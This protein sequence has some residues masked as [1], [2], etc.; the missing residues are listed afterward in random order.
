M[1]L[2]LLFWCRLTGS[3]PETHTKRQATQ[4]DY[5]PSLLGDG[6]LSYWNSVLWGKTYVVLGRLSQPRQNKIQHNTPDEPSKEGLLLFVLFEPLFTSVST[7]S[8]GHHPSLV[9]LVQLP[10]LYIKIT[11]LTSFFP[12]PPH[13]GSNRRTLLVSQDRRHLFVTSWLYSMLAHTKRMYL[14]LYCFLTETT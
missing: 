13:L 1:R 8:R 5:L 3:H 7:A 12:H 6:G 9:S 10:P 4:H 2:N 11:L 14:L